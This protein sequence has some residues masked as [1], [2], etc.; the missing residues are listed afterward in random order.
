[1]L[2]YLFHKQI[3]LKMN[4]NSNLTLMKSNQNQ[5][6]EV[7]RVLKNKASKLPIGFIV[8]AAIGGGLFLYSTRKKGTKSS[9][10]ITNLAKIVAP[11][12][13]IA[14]L[15]KMVDNYDNERSAINIEEV[16]AEVS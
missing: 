8:G 14:I 3:T 1:M 9:N 16:E 2:N 7:I 13:I 11:Y 6:K 10:A 15:D 12:V 4:T 5:R